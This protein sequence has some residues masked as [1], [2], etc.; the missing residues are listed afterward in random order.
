MTA[1]IGRHRPLLIGMAAT[2]LA[3]AAVPIAW[4]ATTTAPAPAHTAT[5]AVAP[6]RGCGTL[7]ALDLTGVPDAPSRI[8]SAAPAT[9]GGTTYCDVRGYTAPQTQF[10]VKLPTTTWHGQYLQVGCGGFCGDV[11]TE[12]ANP[13]PPQAAGCAAV[14]DDELVIAS[15]N[16]GHLG[17]SRLDG[18]WGLDEPRLRTV[19]GYT[20]EHQLADVAKTVI[21]G[22]YGRSATRSYYDGCSDGGREALMEAQRYPDDFDGI[23][24]GAPALDATDFAGE[25][26]AWVY[27]A[28]TDAEGKQ[29]LGT[30]K[31]S[32]LHAAV[33]RACAGSSGVI[34]DPRACGFDPATVTCP[35]GTDAANCLTPAQVDVVRKFY[36]G[37]Q[38]PAGRALY[39][40]GLP[41]G[42]ELAWA[43]W[44]ISPTGDA[45][46]TNAA[47][48]ALN[49]QNY[50]AFEHPVKTDLRDIAFTD[51]EYAK[52]QQGARINNSTDPD[53]TAFR[54]HGGKIILYH[55]WADQ[56]IPPFGTVAYY[57]AMTTVTKNADS[58]SRLYMIPAQYHCLGGGDP[59]A[60]A[61]LLTPLMTW[62][63]TGDAPAALTFPTVQPAPGQPAALTVQPFDPH[64]TVAGHGANSDYDWIG[65]FR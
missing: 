16:E 17:A 62:V 24:A 43:G 22:Y 51:A 40:G 37:P 39:P 3:A 61:D 7:T 38:D 36:S 55:G 63:T 45:R 50:L 56:A 52:L 30:D 4:S 27:R 53:L 11:P 8:L 42:S 65:R 1:V 6:V 47:Q 44:D 9:V 64:Q 60:S 15:D 13:A 57:T 35:T 12:G 5:T 23:L 25:L 21:Q 31:L 34:D 28:N 58:F 59:Q 29:I 19:F 32:A 48:F 46:S 2:V 33:L 14:A 20:S 41:Y 54:R 18:L 49:F 10:E 26:S